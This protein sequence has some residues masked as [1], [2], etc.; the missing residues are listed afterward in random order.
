MKIFKKNQLAILVISLMLITAG[1]LNYDSLSNAKADEASVT[2]EGSTNV[3]SI[4]D[5]EL[6]NANVVENSNT[7]QTNE[8]IEEN[9][10]NN[11]N[12]ENKEN[13][14]NK[15]EQAKETNANADKVSS[16]SK[17]YFTT[18]KL[19]R[20]VMYSQMIER[21]QNVV[22]SSNSAPEQKA[23]SQE[24]I[25]KIND[26]QNAIMIAENLLTT[27]GFS[28][29]IVFVNGDSISVIIG[30]DNLSTDEIA[31]IQNIISREL[32]AQPENIHISIK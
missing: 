7:I 10:E 1:Y 19:E 27:K 16:N 6:V 18:S 14:E 11:K 15:Q 9:N 2:P 13:N 25:N 32:S 12:E 26:L 22:N 29:N 21:Y 28:Q 8:Q 23:I 31:Q 20:N 24:E 4:G 5:A 30:K 17:D 3:A